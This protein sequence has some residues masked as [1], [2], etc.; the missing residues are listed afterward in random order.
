MK[1]KNNV[2]SLIEQL[3]SIDSFDIEHE[4]LMIQFRFLSEIE[5]LMEEQDEEWSKKKL[6]KEISTSASYITQ[7]FRGSKPLN[8]E[9]IAKIQNAFKV[10]FDIIAR[11]VIDKNVL[12]EPPMEVVYSETRAIKSGGIQ[13]TV[14]TITEI[15]LVSNM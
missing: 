6:A 7:L 14:P 1:S 10:K 2:E 8:M 15:P 3:S 5:R 4:K 11:K 13:L 12:Y 9:T